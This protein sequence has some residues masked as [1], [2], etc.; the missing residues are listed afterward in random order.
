MPPTSQVFKSSDQTSERSSPRLAVLLSIVP[1][2]LVTV[3]FAMRLYG[4]NFDDQLLLHPDELAI[5]EVVV[6]LGCCLGTPG[7]AAATWPSPLSHFFS[8]QLAPYN[9]RFFNYGSLPLYLLAAV[10]RSAAALGHIIPGLSSWQSATDIVHTTWI[11]RWLSALFDTGSLIVVYQLAKH[12]FDRPVA[13]IAMTFATFTVLA[14]QLS[15]FYA[16]DTILTFLVLVTL[17]GAVRFAQAGQWRW[18]IVMGSAFGAALATKT[19]AFPLIIPILAATAAI[20]WNR[21]DAD[22]PSIAF[23]PLRRLGLPSAAPVNA[24]LFRLLAALTATIVVFAICEPY[25]LIDHAQLISDIQTQNG[26]IVN[27][28][29]QV[30]YTIQFIGTTPYLYFL[31]NLVLWYLGPALGVTACAGAVWLMWRGLRGKLQ[32]PQVLL[33]LWLVPYALVVGRFWA[34]FGRYLLPITPILCIAAAAFLVWLVRRL[35]GKKQIFGWVGIAAIIVS[36]VAWA[37]AFEHIYSVTNPQVSASRWIY[38]HLAPTTPFAT[39][40]EWDRS[41][42]FCLPQPNQCPPGYNGFQMNLYD[43]DNATKVDR[44]VHVLTHD[45][46]IVMSTQRFI[47]SIPRDSKQYPITTRYYRL[48]FHNQLN[49]RLVKRFAVHPQIGPWVIDDF[50][51]DENFTVFDH[52]DV[53]IFRRVFGITPQRARYLL[54]LA[55]IADQSL[56]QADDLPPQSMRYATA[57]GIGSTDSPAVQNS[58]TGL[59]PIRAGATHQDSRLMLNQAQWAEDQQAPTYDQMFPPHGFGM[60]HPIV[61]WLVLIEL[62]GL[63]TIPVTLTVFRGL[64]DRGWVIAKTMGMI[65]LGWILWVLVSLGVISYTFTS[66]W[67]II[68][69]LTLV[70]GTLWWL[71][72]RNILD[73]FRSC[74]N[75]IMIGEILFL[76]GFATFVLLR[77]W[78]PDLGHQFSPVSLSNT[79]AGRMGEKQLELAFLNAITRSQTFPPLDPFFAG[80]FINYYY[81]GYVIVGTLCKAT[82]IAPA[83]GFNLAIATFFGL[84]VGT[85]YSIGRSVSGSRLVGLLTVILLACIGNLNSLVQAVQDMQSAT[86]I[87]SRI[88]FF[89]GVAEFASGLFQATVHGVPIPPFDFWGPTRLIPPLGINFA[90]FP[91]FTFLFGDLHAHLMALPMDLAVVALSLSVVRAGITNNKSSNRSSAIADLDPH[92]GFRRRLGT[93][94]GS[95]ILVAVLLGAFLLGAVEATNPLDFPTYLAVLTLGFVTVMMFRGKA[96]WPQSAATQRLRSGVIALGASALCAAGALVLFP[97]LSQG[98]HPVFDSGLG[99]AISQVDAVRSGLLAGQPSLRGHAL[100]QAVHDAISTPLLI[101]WEIFGLF[102]F[103]ISTWAVVILSMTI[104]ER[105]N[106]LHTHPRRSLIWAAMAVTVVAA[107]SVVLAIAQLWLLA[108]L[109]LSAGAIVGIMTLRRHHLTPRTAWLCGLILLAIGLS[110]FPEV[111]YIRDYLSGSL[112]FRMNTV[113]K[114]YNQI[115][116]L[117]ALT[118]AYCFGTLVTLTR[119]TQI[120]RKF[121]KTASG[122]SDK[123]HRRSGAGGLVRA[124]PI[125]STIFAVGLA[126]SLIYTFAGTVAR[127]TYRQT[128]LPENSVPFTLDGMAF[129]KEAYPGDYAGINWLNAHVHG[130][131]VIL[132]ADQAYYNW[133]SRVVQFTGLPTLLGGIYESA[134]R[135]PDQ[136]TSRQSVLEEI[137]GVTPATANRSIQAAFDISGCSTGSERAARCMA[138][139]LL[140]AYHVSYIYVGLMERQLWPSGVGKFNEMQG[141]RRVFDD[142]GVSIYHVDGSAT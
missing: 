46:Y 124:H 47:D 79:G 56:P 127:E 77:M 48:L 139:K 29:I 103:L 88:P 117:L 38:T 70:A 112:A 102:L 90:E 54:T 27:H 89:G 95:R 15:H 32:A 19:S 132:E 51:A 97:P 66:I 17:L 23:K 100:T 129:M 14:I 87:H 93:L 2:L 106:T 123:G 31:R 41:L 85:A 68:A 16:V 50:G 7:S 78:Y 69:T 52:P 107:P 80:G 131:P 115:W 8:A 25:G 40:G 91:L 57:R 121:A 135:Y 64:A 141:V 138:R 98:Y 119:R 63:I 96:S 4:Y 137:Y 125:W 33:L 18:C 39:E 44:L 72:R 92:R 43:P 76:A 12:A 24:A 65:A 101:Y 59:P 84:V 37:F 122:H 99:T 118:S 126:G 71:S 55:L 116:V 36:T 3:G 53:R 1:F 104:C 134:Q 49:F 136:V 11:G 130:V 110:T 34:K 35:P 9:P 42:P 60:S 105:H 61:T 109:W 5:N 21:A 142:G 10:T 113:A 81:F 30:P 82:T 62:L 22:A 108:F 28:S 13:L 67:I 133:R 120:R 140:T 94:L 74:R 75:E 111:F 73:A 83:T 20:A 6:T 45:Q 26:I 114:L 58:A 128:W 86:E